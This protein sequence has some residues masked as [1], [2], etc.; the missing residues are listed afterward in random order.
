MGTPNFTYSVD[1][2]D[3]SHWLPGFCTQTEA[4]RHRADDTADNVI[5]A[6]CADRYG[7][8]IQ[9]LWKRRPHER[10]PDAAARLARECV[11][12]CQRCHRCQYVSFSAEYQD[13]SWFASCDT[14][15]LSSSVAHFHT[16]ALPQPPGCIAS[17]ATPP[18]YL[19]SLD[20]VL[21][22]RKAWPHERRQFNLVA[23]LPRSRIYVKKFALSNDFTGRTAE[24]SYRV[25]VNSL[26]RLA[27]AKPASGCRGLG[28][29]HINGFPTLLH[30]NDSLRIIATVIEEAPS[31]STPP[32]AREQIACMWETLQA[33]GVQHR[34][35]ACKNVRLDSKGIFTLLDFDASIA[36]G[37]VWSV[38]RTQSQQIWQ[39][40]QQSHAPIEFRTFERTLLSCRPQ[41]DD[42]RGPPEI[43]AAVLQVS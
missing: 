1:A 16:I 43:N 41:E 36:F 13:C 23:R 12:F 40:V 15:A 26:C 25:E 28:H 30:R 7:S 2:A 24:E 6:G 38:A 33:A 4:S 11:S 29:A 32:P 37:D 21:A 9:L 39:R 34:D 35:V 31:G 5:A 20:A 18:L 22:R 42:L 27:T 19:R 14:G 17:S 8:S 3:S 10:L